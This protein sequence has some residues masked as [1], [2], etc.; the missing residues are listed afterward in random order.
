M[1]SHIHFVAKMVHKCNI[2]QLSCNP[3]VDQTFK[4]FGNPKVFIQTKYLDIGNNNYSY[5][6]QILIQINVTWQITSYGKF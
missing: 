3:E 4:F 1:S 6:C 2:L 5:H